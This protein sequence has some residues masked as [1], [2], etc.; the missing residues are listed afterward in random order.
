MHI[1]SKNASLIWKFILAVVGTI[2]LIDQTGLFAGQPTVKFFF[3]FTNLSNL[4]VVVYFWGA[5]VHAL[6]SGDAHTP[7]HPKLK[8]ALTL[9]ITVTFLVAHFMLDGGMVFVN[10]EFRW[11]MLVVHYLVPIATILDW[12]LFDAK[13]HMGKLDPLTWPIFPLCYLV[14]IFVLVLGFGVWAGDQGKWPYPFINLD[15]L[16]VGGVAVNVVALL[17]AFIALGYVYYAIDRFMVKRTN[18]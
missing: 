14:Y 16:G 6:R 4:A 1:A 15:M 12:I 18:S 7:W 5:F 8:Y 9:A 11:P 10:G 2:A 13:G 3:F 17:V